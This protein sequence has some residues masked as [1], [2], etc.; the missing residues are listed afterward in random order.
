MLEMIFNFVPRWLALYKIPISPEAKRRW[1]TYR[2]LGCALFVTV[3]T[4]GLGGVTTILDICWDLL[5]HHHA[6]GGLDINMRLVWWFSG[7]LV[8]GLGEWFLSESRFR[9][10][11]KPVASDVPGSTQLGSTAL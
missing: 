9:L 7:A 6:V 4:L 3:V 11:S 1:G 2:K 5:A 10:P 8:V